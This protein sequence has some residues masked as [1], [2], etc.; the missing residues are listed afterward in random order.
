[1]RKVTVIL[2]LTVLAAGGVLVALSQPRLLDRLGVMG[3]IGWLRS[4]TRAFLEDI[5]FKDFEKAASY[6]SPEEQET[7]DIPFLIERLFGVKPEQLDIMEYEILFS[8]IDSTGLRARVKSRVKVKHLLQDEIHD[9]ELML[10]FHRSSADAPW[11][12]KLESS[13]RML[14]GEEG[15]KH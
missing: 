2:V 11:Y 9:R 15:K 4:T 14:S 6:H 3:E 7:V 12:M 10:Y 1:M 8:K 5:Q 13:L